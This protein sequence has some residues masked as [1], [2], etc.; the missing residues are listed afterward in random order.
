MTE[1]NC[2]KC[3]KL[4]DTNVKH[5]A[6]ESGKLCHVDCIPRENPPVAPEAP[7]EPA[8]PEV[9][10]TP[11]EAENPVTIISKAQALAIFGGAR[12]TR[13][14]PKPGETKPQPADMT[15]RYFVGQTKDGRFF[16]ELREINP[17]EAE[18]PVDKYELTDDDFIACGENPP[19]KENPMV[20]WDV[21]LDGEVID[22]VPYTAST[23][24]EEVKRSLI[25]HDG[26]DPS[27]EVKRRKRSHQT[28]H[29]PPT[30]ENPG[31]WDYAQDTKATVEDVTNFLDGGIAFGTQMMPVYDALLA[32]VAQNEGKKVSKHIMNKLAPMFPQLEFR[33]SPEYSW[34]AIKVRSPTI[35]KDYSPS[36]TL[37]YDSAPMLSVE[38]F[39]KNNTWAPHA[40]G[41]VA[42]KQAG[43]AKAAEWVAR[44]N[45]MV[46]DYGALIKE[47]EEYDAHYAVPILKADRRENPPTENPSEGL[48]YAEGDIV[49]TAFDPRIQ[50]T[51]KLVPG[52][53]HRGGIIQT[54]TRTSCPRCGGKAK[55]NVLL[56]QSVCYRCK[57]QFPPGDMVGIP[58]IIGN[59]P[60]K[61]NPLTK[62]E[63]VI[64]IQQH[65]R[66]AALLM[67]SGQF[68]DA[69]RVITVA[70]GLYE[71]L[72]QSEKS[73]Y[74]AM[75]DEIERIYQSS[76]EFQTKTNPSLPKPV[77]TVKCPTCHGA[78]L[79]KVMAG[80]FKEAQ[81]C[82]YC[83][84]DTYKS[85]FPDGVQSNPPPA[86]AV[87]EVLQGFEEAKQRDMPKKE[88]PSEHPVLFLT[89]S[90]GMAQQG[91]GAGRVYGVIYQGDSLM[92][93]TLSK[94]QAMGVLNK[95]ATQLGIKR[96]SLMWDGDKSK[97]VPMTET[98]PPTDNIPTK[99]NFRKETIDEGM[100][101]WERNVTGTKT[102]PIR[103]TSLVVVQGNNVYFR[104]DAKLIELIA[105]HTGMAVHSTEFAESGSGTLLFYVQD[106]ASGS[107]QYGSLQPC[108]D[109]AFIRLEPPVRKNPPAAKP[110]AKP[111][112]KVP[113]ASKE[114][115]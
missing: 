51:R 75:F 12:M 58:T 56:G 29:N 59:P 36:F 38:N 20:F 107:L 76:L 73:E 63:V 24:A 87:P 2:M 91:G 65:I 82:P 40:A 103:D 72:T 85:A 25:N 99:E 74:R 22:S 97:F 86:E 42:K 47:M 30:K 98:N 41:Q 111:E 16:T 33:Y 62:S 88:N 96:P 105:K 93:T 100:G 53:V 44:Y 45:K 1:K 39:K 108:V 90:T 57:R 3:G 95:T 28:L 77:Y 102:I 83:D 84:R 10:S 31:G 110:E 14:L 112:P 8:K 69:E 54:P 37:A 113:E 106:K 115:K 67:E 4:V 17:P 55:W 9:A 92:A 27:I 35:P 43:L 61:E 49:D 64:K 80:D 79:R 32:I 19:T 70:A 104:N 68:A 5:G 6:T 50:K 71:A 18:N 23:D 46:A 52:E 101:W 114:A 34:T 109:G 13:F 7:K 89:A 78:R 66:S 21:I 26:Y 60:E 48:V 11:A 15:G 81:L 94:E